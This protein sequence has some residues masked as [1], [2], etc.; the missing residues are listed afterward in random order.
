MEMSRQ[1]EGHID[2]SIRV[3]QRQSPHGSRQGDVGDRTASTMIAAPAH[4]LR[5]R[6]A[7]VLKPIR[8]SQDASGGL[9][10]VALKRSLDVEHAAD[11]LI[12]S[13]PIALTGT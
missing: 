12:Q 5:T 3:G 2:L 4:E 13:C 8:C 10:P 11:M 1:A 7:R 9:K 6:A